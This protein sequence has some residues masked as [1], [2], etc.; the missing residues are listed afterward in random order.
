MSI[1][2][3]RVYIPS[4]TAVR[5]F[6][7]LSVKVLC[8]REEIINST[9]GKRERCILKNLPLLSDGEAATPVFD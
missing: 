8:F 1:Q 4:Q 2:E 9:L 3:T 7:F 5:L 6:F